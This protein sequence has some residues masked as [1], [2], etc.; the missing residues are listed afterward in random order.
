MLQLGMRQQLAV[1]KRLDFGVYLADPEEKEEKVLLPSK[2]VPEGTK[3]GDQI[4]VFLYRDSKDRM[5]AT[6]RTPLLQLGQMA[7][8]MVKQVTKIGA[9]L[10]WGLE[11][12]LFLPFHEQTYRVREGEECLAALYIDKSDR[13]CATMKVYHYLRTDAPYTKDDL[14]EGLIYESSDRFGLF[15]AVDNCYSALIPRQQVHSNLCPG[16]RISCRVTEVR[17]DGKLSLSPR[18]K[19]WVQMD[20]DAAQILQVIDEFDGVLPFTDKASPEVIDRT[21]GMSK[22]AFK[23]AVGRLLKQGKITITST[24]IRK[25]ERS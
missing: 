17:E 19:A 24:A 25:K 6:T 11:K 2:Q 15:V 3:P 8:L 4:E 20:A 12:D 9:F 1:V 18:E 7:P 14:V 13:L 21:F 16:Q 22:A 23:R 5:I 10:D